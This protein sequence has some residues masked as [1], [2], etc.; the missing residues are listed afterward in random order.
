MKIEINQKGDLLI[1]R[2]GKMKIQACPKQQHKGD[3]DVAYVVACGDW[4]P[5]FREPRQGFYPGSETIRVVKLRICRACYMC[6]PENF[7]DRREKRK[8]SRARTV[9]KGIGGDLRPL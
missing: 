7:T 5:L 1:E 9:K 3:M 8:K 2:G 4:C 6:N